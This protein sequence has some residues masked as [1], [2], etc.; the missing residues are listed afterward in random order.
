MTTA[1]RIALDPAWNAYITGDTSDQDFPATANAFQRHLLGF[2]DAFVAK[3]V[4]A[5][6]LRVAF[7]A[8]P[9][10]IG[11]NVVALY[12]LRVFNNGP[13]G[14]DGVVLS[15]AIPRGMAF[16]SDGVRRA[17]LHKPCQRRN[18]RHNHLLQP[19]LDSKRNR[20]FDLVHL[21]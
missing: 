7:R 18:K 3:V 20:T 17:R 1:S 9:K 4:I 6:D 2:T 16:E 8:S 13:D 21:P 10:T 5:G 11:P 15:S 14:S 19:V 12:L